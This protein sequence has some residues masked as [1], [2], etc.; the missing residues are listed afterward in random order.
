MQRLD[1]K[2]ALAAYNEL[3]A[4]DPDDD[5]VIMTL[6]DLFY[7]VGQPNSALR[8]LDRHLVGL[9]RKGQ[10]TRVRTILEEMVERH[11][12][13]A[14]LVDRLT[15]LYIHQGN[16]DKAIKV[17]DKLGEAQLD[18]GQD[19]QATETIQKIL[20]LDPPNAAS[21]QELLLKLHQGPALQG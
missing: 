17:L 20:K 12:A 15:R 4:S 2:R 16:K 21:Y 14:G 13:E 9:V 5:T 8:K 7:K 1:W 11:P 6:V 10:G 19:D 18:D 3:S